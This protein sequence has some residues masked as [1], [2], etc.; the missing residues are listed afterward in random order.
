MQRAREVRKLCQRVR[1]FRGR[2]CDVRSN[3]L[4]LAAGALR[5]RRFFDF[6]FFVVCAEPENASA[7]TTKNAS[8]NGIAERR[9]LP[10]GKLVVLNGRVRIFTER[11][12]VA[13]RQNLHQPFVK[14]VDWVIHDRLE[15]AVVFAMSFLNVVFQSDTDVFVL[16]GQAYL[17]RSQHFNIL[18]RNFRYPICTPV[19]FLFLSGKVVDVEVRGGFRGFVHGQG[20]RFKFDRGASRWGF[21]CGAGGGGA[22][23]GTAATGAAAIGFGRDWSGRTGSGTAAGASTATAALSRAISASNGVRWDG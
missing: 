21:D 2:S 1:F 12:R 20:R 6:F 22:A 11:A 15:A 13:F 5:L 9:N 8:T 3:R 4:R 17:F 7:S 16:A 23:T 19:Q 14:I 18:H 10:N